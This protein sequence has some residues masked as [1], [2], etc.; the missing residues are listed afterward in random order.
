MLSTF[1]SR[2]L[3]YFPF[4]D[5]PTNDV[6]SIISCFLKRENFSVNTSQSIEAFVRDR[7]DTYRA[8]QVICEKD[9]ARQ[10]AFGTRVR[11]ELTLRVVPGE[12][13]RMC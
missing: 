4:I 9:R 3:D 12:S 2:Y 7:P 5:L 1:R 13:F 10:N 11:E 6:V 8:I